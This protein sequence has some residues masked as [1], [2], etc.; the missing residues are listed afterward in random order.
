ML[1]PQPCR[2]IRQ[3]TLTDSEKAQTE[4]IPNSA[5]LSGEDVLG[6]SGCHKHL[7]LSLALQSPCARP[8][9]RCTFSQYPDPKG[10]SRV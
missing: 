7:A 9:D 4:P 6:S 1:N 10:G 3:K 2:N 8:I 5:G